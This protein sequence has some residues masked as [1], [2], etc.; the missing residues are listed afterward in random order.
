MKKLLPQITQRDL[1]YFK[2]SKIDKMAI[3]VGQYYS[4]LKS[5][6][7][8]RFDRIIRSLC[9]K[10]GLIQNKCPL[11]MIL[12]RQIA[13]NSIRIEEAESW[14]I[15]NPDKMWIT[16]VEKWLLLIQKER[17]EAVNLLASLVKMVEKEGKLNTFGNLRD[18]LREEEG[19]PKSKK[20]ELSP[21]GHQ[22]RH[23][24]GITRTK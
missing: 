12:M 3:R 2:K 1:S 9:H 10:Y 14:L 6:Q 19:L 13:L 7:R 15:D 17:R 21:N 4:K 16:D 5:N 22:R 18:G 20:M 8:D 23:Y 24:D 11:E